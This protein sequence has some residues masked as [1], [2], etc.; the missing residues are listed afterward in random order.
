MNDQNRALSAA[1]RCH[2]ELTSMLCEARESFE[3][4]KSFAGVEIDV[5]WLNLCWFHPFVSTTVDA[6]YLRVV[7]NLFIIGDADG[8]GHGHGHGVYYLRRKLKGAGILAKEQDLEWQRYLDKAKPIHAKVRLV[9]DKHFAHRDNGYTWQKAMQESGLLYNELD[10]LISHYYRIAEV[11][12][13]E[14]EPIF[15][16]EKLVKENMKESIENVKTA[17]L[18]YQPV[19]KAEE[20]ERIMSEIHSLNPR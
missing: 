16:N 9:R 5:E 12:A 17:L 20:D 4:W 19:L 2:K 10:L 1:K 11:T 15:L 14:I 6:H 3:I 13:P 18:L 8:K 7:V